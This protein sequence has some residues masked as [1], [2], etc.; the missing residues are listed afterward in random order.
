[1]QAYKSAS[2]IALLNLLEDVSMGYTMIDRYTLYIN[3]CPR[4]HGMASLMS[5]SLAQ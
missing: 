5:F 2:R 4:P 1:M 3:K